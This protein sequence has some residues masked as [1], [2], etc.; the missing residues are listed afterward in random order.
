MKPKFDLHVRSRVIL[1]EKPTK[2]LTALP[3]ANQHQMNRIRGFVSGK[4]VIVGHRSSKGGMDFN[5]ILS[6]KVFAVAADAFS[7]VMEKDEQKRPT[8]VQ[9]LEDGLPYYT[10]SGFYLLSSP[11]Y[12]ALSIIEGYTR[13]HREGELLL[14]MSLDALKGR[15]KA[16]L[17]NLSELQTLLDGTVT[18]MLSDAHNL[19]E[20]FDAKI[21][22]KRKLMVDQAKLAMASA[23]EDEDEDKPTAGDEETLIEYQEL[24]VSPKDGNPFVYLVWS[25]PGQE[26]R[27]FV[28]TREHM[29]EGDSTQFMAACTI[30]EALAHF[31]AGEE[32][33]LIQEGIE[34]GASATVSL[35]RGNAMRPSRMFAGKIEATR[36]NTPEKNLY[37]DPVYIL[38]ALKAW[39]P[40]IV[41]ILHSK[42][43]A[44]PKKDYDHNY[45]V[46]AGRQGEV[47]M[48][49][50]A[51]MKYTPPQAVCYDFRAAMLA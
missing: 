11:E 44:F 9:K 5:K 14:L 25:V 22:K 32:F 49:K 35:A 26:P 29:V 8:K 47:G 19:V 50:T 42:H 2:P 3:A 21:N 39:T 17:T 18:E 6:G 40:G 48:N 33:K 1:A 38:G 28:F 46:A 45:Y 7:P 20:A 43:P 37:G 4:E 41:S 31:R 51:D 23:E 30:E 10:S 36:N 13:L 34:S 12:P 24:T 15:T 27:E 16:T